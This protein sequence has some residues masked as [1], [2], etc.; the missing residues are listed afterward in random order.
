MSSRVDGPAL[1]RTNP[2]VA[3]IWRSWASPFRT[4]GSDFLKSLARLGPA[5]SFP[6][7]RQFFSL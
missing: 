4:R 2:L 7:T 1:R 3:L 5:M 6:A